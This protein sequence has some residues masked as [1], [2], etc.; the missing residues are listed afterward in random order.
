[1]TI[2]V[3][4]HCTFIPPFYHMA[5]HTYIVNENH[6]LLNCREY[7]IKYM[8]IKL[9][10]IVI[11]Q[12]WFGFILNI[13]STYTISNLILEAIEEKMFFYNKL[14]VSVYVYIMQLTIIHTYRY[15]YV[16]CNFHFIHIHICMLVL[17]L[18]TSTQNNN[19]SLGTH[20]TLRKYN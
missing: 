7:L 2:E 20:A 15:M 5:L 13:L 1:M 17:T 6:L 19:N 8:G 4:L 16:I 9:A 12:F 18:T 10:Y 14:S 11:L 3:Y